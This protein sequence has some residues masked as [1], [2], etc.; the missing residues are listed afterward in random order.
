M[1]ADLTIAELLDPEILADQ[2]AVDYA[3]HVR[4][5]DARMAGF[6]R[7]CLSYS[8]LP[9][10]APDALPPTPAQHA[11]VI[12]EYADRKEAVQFDGFSWRP[13]GG[14]QF[15]ARIPASVVIPDAD[16]NARATSFT[17]QI[18]DDLVLVEAA[19]SA[20]KQVYDHA[21]KAVQAFF[22][23][24]IQEPLEA[25]VKALEKGPLI[26]WTNKVIAEE[27][28]A[29]LAEARRLQAD[30]DAA[31]A[32]AA[33]TQHSDMM[34]TAVQVGEKADRA[35]ARAAAPVADLGRSRGSLGGVSTVITTWKYRV[36][37]E[38][39]LPDEYWVIDHQKLAAE[40]KRN[41]NTTPIPGVE[42]FSENG[43]SVR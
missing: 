25:A 23:V 22:K 19:R 13:L 36:V 7:F 37:D 15:V 27:H 11:I 17:R 34:E 1:P 6:I 39:K 43:V 5:R 21:G 29:R 32:A 3:E 18:K 38:A 26:V 2:L 41:K 35:A 9:R 24:G 31:L 33:R 8:T 28:A 16:V 20:E 10:Y 14:A 40:V 42:M 30:A 12:I 4:K